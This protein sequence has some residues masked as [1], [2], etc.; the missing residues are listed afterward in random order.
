MSGPEGPSITERDLTLLRLLGEGL[1]TLTIA[2]R[3]EM[4]ERTVR[5]R[6]R[7]ICDELGVEAPISA[8]VWAVRKGLL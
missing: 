1:S 4:S 3:T 6:L 2:R 7:A 5:R 8:V